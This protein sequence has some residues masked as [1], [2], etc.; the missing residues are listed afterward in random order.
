MT[1][2][3]LHRYEDVSAV[4]GVGDVAWG[5]EWP[6]GAVAVR[7]PGDNPST[8]TWSDI[9]H[10]EAVHGHSGKTVIRYTEPGDRLAGAYQRIMPFLLV[11]NW[12][13]PVVVGPHPDHSDRLRL[14]FLDQATW[15][16][17]TALL[18]G[19]TEAATHDEVAGEIAHT[20]ITPDGGIWCQYFSPL[21]ED[22]Q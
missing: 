12:R 1:E 5:V 3:T 16:F 4:S 21:Q 17:W 22:N 10:V 14:V 2:F 13:Q 19:S 11:G 7:W 18:D 8:A 9:R 6:D 20:F 15:A